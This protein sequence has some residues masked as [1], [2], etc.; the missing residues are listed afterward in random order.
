MTGIWFKNQEFRPENKTQDSHIAYN[1]VAYFYVHTM[2]K[3]LKRYENIL[4]IDVG[5]R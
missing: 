1:P 5:C 4:T 3:Y 2:Y